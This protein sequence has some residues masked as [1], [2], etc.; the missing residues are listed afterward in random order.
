MENSF[1][2]ELFDTL[3]TKKTIIENIIENLEYYN[4]QSSNPVM[5]VIYRRKSCC[6][7]TSDD[8]FY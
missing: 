4:Y 3:R 7:I 2:Y 5:Q 6:F 8:M 1:L